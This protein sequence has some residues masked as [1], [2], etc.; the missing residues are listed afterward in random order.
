MGQNSVVT[1]VLP[2]QQLIGWFTAHQHITRLKLSLKKKKKKKKTFSSNFFWT[3]LH[4]TFTHYLLI[5][6]KGSLMIISGDGVLKVELEMSVLV[7]NF[8]KILWHRK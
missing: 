3:L 2:E 4:A 1:C 8:E 7:E 5:D 6:T